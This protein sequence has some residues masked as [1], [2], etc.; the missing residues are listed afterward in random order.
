MNKERK[1]HLTNDFS[2]HKFCGDC[3]DWEKLIGFINKS[4]SNLTNDL[5]NPDET[6][7]YKKKI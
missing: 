3:P 5:M 4:N 7:R 6:K 2:C 1:A